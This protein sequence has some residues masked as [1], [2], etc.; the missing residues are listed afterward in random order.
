MPTCKT[1]LPGGSLKLI[2]HHIS[3]IQRYEQLI[4]LKKD[5]QITLTES[6]TTEVYK[7]YLF[8]TL[9]QHPYCYKYYYM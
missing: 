4:F 7:Q 3:F 9:A 1:V 2:I 8:S 5:L 6:P